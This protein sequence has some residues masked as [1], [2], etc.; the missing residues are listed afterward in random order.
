MYY[1]EVCVCIRERQKEIDRQ[2]G[3]LIQVKRDLHLG[4]KNPLDSSWLSP[5]RQHSMCMSL[6]LLQFDYLN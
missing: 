2:M 5:S 1:M 4:F 3:D 6:P